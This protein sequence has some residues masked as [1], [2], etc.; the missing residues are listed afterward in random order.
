[1]HPPKPAS[2]GPTSR[3][4]SPLAGPQGG[5]LAHACMGRA[6]H[7]MPTPSVLKL[8][9]SPSFNLQTT[10]GAFRALAASATRTPQTSLNGELPQP[11]QPPPVNAGQCGGGKAAAGGLGLGLD[12]G[13]S[14]LGEV[15]SLQGLGH[16]V[17]DSTPMTHGDLIILY[18][19]GR[20]GERG[21][22]T[23]RGRKRTR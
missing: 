16:G 14:T 4:H 15:L 2:A 10:W 3:Y 21:M 23:G 8:P 9:V 18:T 7:P 11:P 19:V 5:A 22:G 1:M 6:V 12:P 13:S 17:A 20:D